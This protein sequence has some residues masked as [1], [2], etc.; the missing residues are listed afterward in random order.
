MSADGARGLA[1]LIGS[2]PLPTAEEVFR[3]LGAALGPLL[4]R[5]PDCPVCSRATATR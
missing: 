1:H 2:V 3:G 4:S 5:M